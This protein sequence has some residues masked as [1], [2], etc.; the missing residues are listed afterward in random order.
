MDEYGET[1]NQYKSLVQT[2]TD[3]RIAFI[4]RTKRNNPYLNKMV[5]FSSG[6]LAYVTNQGVVKRTDRNS[7]TTEP[8]PLN[9]P[10]SPEYDT[11]NRPISNYLVS[12]TPMQ[13]E[14]SV[15][16]EGTNIV[17]S[18]MINNTE[19]TY[20]GC[21]ANANTV[22]TT[23]S[24]GDFSQPSIIAFE[25]INNNTRVPYWTFAKATLINSAGWGYPKTNGQFVSMRG[26]ASISQTMQ[27]SAGTYAMSFGAVGWNKTANPIR[28][29]LNDVDVQTVTPTVGV[30]TDYTIDLVISQSG[31]NTIVFQ[32]TTA[33][34]ASA[35]RNVA[36]DAPIAAD[37]KMFTFESC[38]Q[39]AIDSGNQYFSLQNNGQQCS[40]TNDLI[41]AMSG[42]I[43]YAVSG[44]V[45][46]WSAPNKGRVALLVST[47]SLSLL[48]DEGVPV[49]N[50][51]TTG[52]TNYLG[53]YADKAERSM[54]LFNGGAQ[55]YEHDKCRDSTNNKY[56]GLQNS[57]SG[58]KAQ[59]V[60]SDD[61]VQLRK[62]GK[63]GN[64]TKT[65]NLWSGG[66]WSNAVYTRDPEEKGNYYLM[67]KDDG[68]MCVYRGSGPNDEQEQIWCSNT[69]GGKPNPKYAAAKGK[70]G[71]NWIAAGDTLA[72]GEF[73]GSTDGSAYLLLGTNGTL[74]LYTSK[75]E[76]NCKKRADG[77][78][79]G[80]PGGGALHKLSEIGDPSVLSKQA[81]I[82][83]D[84]F[85][86]AEL[87]GNVTNEVDTNLFKNYL[88][89]TTADDK[90][91][92][93]LQEAELEQKLNR[94]GLNKEGFS[95][96]LEDSE[97]K[98]QQHNYEYLAWSLL[99]MSALLL[100]IKIARQ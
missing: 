57:S 42:G 72:L 59:C 56:Y 85:A 22:S 36:I 77:N 61:L 84:S 28:I 31:A 6:E 48:N 70:Y 33:D 23:L 60:F 86:H 62:Y 27:V 67:V 17:A 95:G 100:S 15:G 88:P 80:G 29:R 43:S 64:C 74:A 71:K 81:Y 25:T 51:P 93:D 75:N 44:G 96:I 92:D 89:S 4:E 46:L 11:P 69:A 5:K 76:L 34:L 41:G 14:Q 38:K 49:F 45:A 91:T 94:L 97:L 55:D 9:I 30:W 53:C 18:R 65:G 32:G 7:S 73:V 26:A 98:L 39:S 63:A 50:T 40:T 99:A 2:D 12:G 3:N 37:T 47:G 20:M 35:I 1:L 13:P 19:A 78:M 66:P 83:A 21:F 52:P 79:W 87:R 68:N 54:N 10:W 8:M 82:D 58:E 90:K 16:Y 24:N